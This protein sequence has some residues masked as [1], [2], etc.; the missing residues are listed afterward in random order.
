LQLYEL[1]K[2]NNELADKIKK[3]LITMFNKEYTSNYGILKNFKAMINNSQKKSYVL[4]NL[5][6]DHHNHI[7]IISPN[8]YLFDAMLLGRLFRKFKNSN[9]TES[10]L[11]IVYAGNDHVK[12][13]ID[14]FETV[15]NVNMF[16]YAASKEGNIRCVIA[17]ADKF[18][19]ID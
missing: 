16:K 6:Q 15:L 7:L 10:T 4:S 12:I 8:K 2:E 5:L 19:K 18:P 14:F 17:E 11:K 3:Y 13:Y 1:R 9:H